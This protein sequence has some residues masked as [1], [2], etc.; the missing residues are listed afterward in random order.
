MFLEG[1]FM[2]RKDIKIKSEFNN[3]D[4]N[5]VFND[6]IIPLIFVEISVYKK[7]EG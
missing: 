6:H 1:L 3:W 4:Y 7:L 5:F 2:L